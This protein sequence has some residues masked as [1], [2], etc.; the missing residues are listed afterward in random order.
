MFLAFLGF[1]GGSG[2]QALGAWGAQVDSLSYQDK[3]TSPMP[4]W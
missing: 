3:H 2:A 4:M 1:G